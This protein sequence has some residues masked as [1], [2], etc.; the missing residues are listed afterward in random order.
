M[1]YIFLRTPRALFFYFASL[2]VNPV[3]SLSRW[4]SFCPLSP[5]RSTSFFFSLSRFV[6]LCFLTHPYALSSFT[7]RQECQTKLDFPCEHPTKDIL[8]NSI[9][10]LAECWV[11]NF[12]TIGVVLYKFISDFATKGTTFRLKRKFCANFL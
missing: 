8:C 1:E 11:F 2:F 4:H 3:L 7:I 10:L 5:L 12:A 9:L 6:I